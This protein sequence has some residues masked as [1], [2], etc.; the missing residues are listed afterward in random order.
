MHQQ[1]Q[2][3]RSTSCN[4][5]HRPPR[6]L[7]T[8]SGSQLVSAQCL[9]TNHTEL[10]NWCPSSQVHILA[11]IMCTPCT[12]W[13]RTHRQEFAGMPRCTSCSLIRFYSSPLFYYSSPNFHHIPKSGRMEQGSLIFV[14]HDFLLV[15]ALTLINQ[16][17]HLCHKFE[18]SFSQMEPT[19]C[20]EHGVF[21]S[22]NVYS[23]DLAPEM[24]GLSE[25]SFTP[26]K[27]PHVW[28][29]LKAG[30]RFWSSLW[31]W[32]HLGEKNI[33]ACPSQLTQRSRSSCLSACWASSR[34]LLEH[35]NYWDHAQVQTAN[36]TFTASSALGLNSNLHHLYSR[37][38]SLSLCLHVS[39]LNVT[40]CYLKA[41]QKTYHLT[42]LHLFFI[43][44]L[45]QGL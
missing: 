41:K 2:S 17:H 32:I 18:C 31:V 22:R 10:Q 19:Q 26:L 27:K 12:A 8:P 40:V 37:S 21:G 24:R 1:Q 39:K 34:L 20:A 9:T 3:H 29:F 6:T 14:Q 13:L 44:L 42:L 45:I 5:N 35:I 25:H 4:A 23:L 28:C 38:H 36:N 7:D 16:R 15:N 33:Q 43:L 11:L 30:E